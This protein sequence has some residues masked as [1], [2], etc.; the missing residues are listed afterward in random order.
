MKNHLRKL[1]R[2]NDN[3]LKKKTNQDF[4]NQNPNIDDPNQIENLS[5]ED[6][7]DIK[8]TQLEFRLKNTNSINGEEKDYYLET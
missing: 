5:K 3:M 7:E 6:I 2:D 8:S 1:N 4:N